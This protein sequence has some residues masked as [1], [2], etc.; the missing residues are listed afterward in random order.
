MCSLRVEKDETFNQ[1]ICGIQQTSLKGVKYKGRLG[2]IGN[3]LG[4]VQLKYDHS[5][6]L[7]MHKLESVL[8]NEAHKILRDFEIQMNHQI[9]TGRPDLELINKDE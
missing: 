6:K 7:Y 3:P 9:P 1:I 5:T 4:I 8:A 2:E